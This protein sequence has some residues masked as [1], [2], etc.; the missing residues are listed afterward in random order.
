M[1]TA[2]NSPPDV[3]VLGAGI[4]GLCCALSAREKG[5][6]VTII[7]RDPPGEATSFGNAGIISPWS[8][9]PQC[10]PGVWKNVPKWLLDPKGPVKVRWRDLA[11]IMP[12]AI[13][14]LG[15]S[16]EKKVAKI[17][18]AMDHLMRG[19][20][21]AYRRYLDG[22]GKEHLLVDSWLVTIFRGDA[23]P[24]KSDVAW[25]LRLERGAPIEFVGA[26]DLRDIEPDVSNE[27]HTA[28]LLKGQARTLS[29]VGICKALA[30]KAALQ[31]VSFMTADVKALQPQEDGTISLA[32]DTLIPTRKLVLC[33]GIWSAEL[34]R[35][36]G[37]EVPL[38]AE[39]GYHLEFSDPGVRLQNSVQDMAGK[40]IISSMSGGIRTAGTAEF[41]HVD[42]APNYARARALA[43][44]SKRVLPLLNT[45]SQK[46][47][48]GIRPSFPDNLPAIGP[49][50]N[51]PN[52]ITAFGHSHYGLGMAPATGRI[53]ADIINDTAP[54]IDTSAFGIARFRASVD[55]KQS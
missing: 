6:S 29:P 3:T 19:N 46:E 17:A 42:A 13:R 52:L 21:D 28:V 36:L 27:Y 10:T 39:R 23:K 43:P 15:N 50:P 34:L 37:V 14:F 41:A 48:M 26:A 8:C 11:S 40:I 45:E 53:V 33:G 24:K 38:M 44:L 35:P 4:V 5:L 2:K 18:D 20:V 16:T 47:W 55:V 30:E 9:I 22:T 25:R 7:D 1:T 12:W 31:G 32:T 54:N 51:F 49:V